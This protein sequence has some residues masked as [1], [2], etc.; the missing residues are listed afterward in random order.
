VTP[1]LDELL[2]ST[3]TQNASGVERVQAALRLELRR[4][5]KPRSWRVDAGKLVLVSWLFIGA[6]AV[7]LVSA[8]ET[9]LE[10]LAAKA[11]P[12]L[13]LLGV[14]AVAAWAA[15]APRSRSRLWLGTALGA[16]GA[17]SLV[18][19]RVGVAAPSPLPEWVCTA[20]HFALSIVPVV[21]AVG[22]LRHGAPALL[23]GGVAGIAAGTTGAIIGELACRQSW[24]HVLVFHLTAWLGAVVLTAALSRRTTARSF[25]P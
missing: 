25:A 1:S 18:W 9:S 23:R 16:V 12:I 21:V 15:L 17:V 2:R 5:P 20:S 6:V 14:G 10:A 19:A 8:H 24:Q 13:P 4:N 22:L 7:L 11:W 3:A